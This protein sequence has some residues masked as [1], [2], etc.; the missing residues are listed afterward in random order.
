MATYWAAHGDVVEQ[1]GITN[2]G[3]DT[4]DDVRDD[5]A[6]ALRDEDGD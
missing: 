2:S 4:Y 5:F 1:H 6:D 3:Y